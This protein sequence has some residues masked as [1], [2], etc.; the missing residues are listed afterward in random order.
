MARRILIVEPDSRIAQKL[1]NLFFLEHGRYESDRYEPQIAESVAEAVEQSQAVS[2]HCIIMD[3]AL[4][5]MKGYEAV[6]L[7]RTINNA[8]PIIITTDKNNLDLEAKVRQQEVYYYHIREFG[9][10]ELKTVV[11][12]VF[13]NLQKVEHG[14]RL[15]LSG[16]EPIVLKQLRLYQKLD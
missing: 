8:P 2:Y 4:P 1:F 14:R 5:E 10:D 11:Q 12:G 15:D 7:M 16:A 3:V 13:E 6:R 9:L